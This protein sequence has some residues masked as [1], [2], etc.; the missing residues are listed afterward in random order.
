MS[1]TRLR[2]ICDLL[3]SPLASSILQTHPNDLCGNYYP[4]D[5]WRAWW[6][7]AGRDEGGGLE[8]K[9][10]K[11]V[12]YYNRSVGSD[13]Q[14]HLPTSVASSVDKKIDIPDN[15]VSL[16]DEIRALQLD[17]SPFVHKCELLSR[18][19]CAHNSEFP[20]DSNAISASAHRYYE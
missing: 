2:A 10:I 14:T 1:T 12:R 7:W 11:L 3:A 15:L 13:P 17:R 4:P 20:D 19:Q 18:L 6:D 8:A 5:E 9:W 16:I